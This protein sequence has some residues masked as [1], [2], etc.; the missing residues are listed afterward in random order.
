[1]VDLWPNDMETYDELAD[2]PLG[3]LKE[4]ASL[5]GERTKNVVRAE[6]RV[7]TTNSNSFDRFGIIGS[8]GGNDDSFLY[9]FFIVA[10][11]LENY[12]FRLFVVRQKVMALY[13]AI[14][15]L[16]NDALIDNTFPE[17]KG[18]PRLLINAKDQ[19]QF[20]EI[21]LKIFSAPNTQSLIKL[22]VSQSK[23]SRKGPARGPCIEESDEA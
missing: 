9:E 11:F 1:M 16:D 8:T 7:T 13:P 3:I 2:T 6:V 12:K 18:K 20:E 17:A 14:V 15:I 23:T 5:L 4:Q 10:P 19:D 22:L 21:L